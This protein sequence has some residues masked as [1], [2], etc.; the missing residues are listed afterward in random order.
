[1]STS[2]GVRSFGWISR[3]RAR[4]CER[5]TEPADHH[6]HR[7]GLDNEAHLLVVVRELGR[8]DGEPDRA[9][10]ARREG[11]AP[12][13]RRAVG[14]GERTARP[15]RGRSTARLRSPARRVAH[16]ARN[17]E[18]TRGETTEVFVQ[19]L[20][21]YSQT[22]GRTV[23]IEFIEGSGGA[24]DEVAAVTR[25]VS[26]RRCNRS[27]CGA[28]R[29]SRARSPTS[30]R[31]AKSVRE[32]HGWTRPRVVRRA[33]PYAYTPG[34]VEQG[35]THL[36]E[37]VSKQLAGKPAIHAGDE[38]MHTQPRVLRSI[39]IETGPESADAVA[40]SKA[41]FA[42]RVSTSSNSSRTHSTR[43]LRGAGRELIAKAQETAGSR[44]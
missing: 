3:S 21:E 15:R 27:P 20:N 40:A 28:G 42:A 12:R 25:Y 41:A 23:E 18:G 9:L 10:L 43:G 33:P 29:S 31:P 26:P 13:T 37:Y 5:H 36:V 24:A 1:M 34:N 44:A 17:D 4:E 14:A 35:R 6:A 7:T 38:A 2:V 8:V 39:Y 30:S 11:D 22:Y 32:L 16:R 19:M